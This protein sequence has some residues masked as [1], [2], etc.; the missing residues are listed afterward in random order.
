MIHSI[1]NAAR[2]VH[3]PMNA[4]NQPIP[5]APNGSPP[6]PAEAPRILS[7][8]ELFVG[9]RVVVIEHAGQQYRLLIT[10]NDRLILQK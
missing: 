5:A 4:I 3:E 10:R 8:T 2:Q 6:G 7:S 1:S 9:S